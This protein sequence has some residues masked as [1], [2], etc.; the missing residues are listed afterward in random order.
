[1]V[2]CRAEEGGHR[3]ELREAFDVA[4]ARAVADTRV[5]SELCLP[6]VQVGGVWVAAKGPEPQV[7]RVGGLEARADLRAQGRG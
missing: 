4:V 2:W 1:M 6:F 3:R 7:G 5:L